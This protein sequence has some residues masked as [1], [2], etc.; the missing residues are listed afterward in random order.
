M[1][2]PTEEARSVASDSDA[3][4]A[5]LAGWLARQAAAEERLTSFAFREGQHPIDL[6]APTSHAELRAWILGLVAE[7]GVV[8]VLTGLADAGRSMTDLATTGALGVRPGDRVALAARIGVLT[9][10]G[11]VARDLESDR[12]LLTELGR[13]ALALAGSRP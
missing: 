6:P 5:A 13:S 3:F 10:A 1:N 11:L 9:A 7:P 12:A 8:A 2:S 4:D